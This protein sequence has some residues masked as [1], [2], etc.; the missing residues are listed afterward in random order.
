MVEE[1]GASPDE[2]EEVVV[3]RVRMPDAADLR[4]H[5]FS[6]NTLEEVKVQTAS[7]MDMQA[8]GQGFQLVAEVDGAVVGTLTLSCND[9]PL[10]AHRAHLGSIVVSSHHQRRG[11]ARRLIEE[12]RRIAHTM[13]IEILET[14]CRADTAAE[15][16]YAHVGFVEYGRLPKGIIE[17][18]GDRHVFDQVY[19][20]LPSDD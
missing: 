6:M 2:P 7:N 1:L 15:T 9:H 13:G 4:E 16:A 5:C 17:P 12:S 8:A 3:R 11:I 10:N 20:Y 18:W 14:S 19:F